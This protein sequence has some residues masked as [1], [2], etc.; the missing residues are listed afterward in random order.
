VTHGVTTRDRVGIWGW[1]HGG[2]ASLYAL[3]VAPD[4]FACGMAMY[5]PTELNSFVAAGSPYSRRIWH[6]YFGDPSKEEERASMRERSPLT[7][8]ERITKPVLIVQG[9]KDE[10]VRQEQADRF[11][12]AM[13]KNRK[14]VVYLLYPDEPH[15]LRR[16]ES[17]ASC[18]AVAERFFHQHLGGR[19]EPIGAELKA[20][21]LDIRAGRGS[22]PWLTAG[23]E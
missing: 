22:H 19:Y 15:D 4:R 2:Y 1:S 8:V 3:A 9:G 13:E 23:G 18:F 11:V 5:G 7:H 10:V 21:G 6:H 17:W 16:A 14:P 12:A 20:P